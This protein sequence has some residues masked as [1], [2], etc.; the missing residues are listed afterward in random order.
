MTIYAKLKTMTFDELCA[1]GFTAETAALIA[2]NKLRLV[3]IA[4]S[5][6]FC[7]INIGRALL[8]NDGGY[9]EGE[10]KRCNACSLRFLNAEY[11]E[12]QNEK[13]K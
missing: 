9:C 8:G 1:V 11:T 4:K 6:E 13:D 12:V 2:T 3:D 5:K 7:P 10:S